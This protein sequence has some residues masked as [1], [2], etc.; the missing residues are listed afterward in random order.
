M[1]PAGRTA[2]TAAFKPLLLCQPAVGASSFP[3]VYGQKPPTLHEMQTGSCDTRVA[4]AKRFGRPASFKGG[5]PL[6]A[7]LADHR[8]LHGT[9]SGG[10]ASLSVDPAVHELHNSM[11]A[12]GQFT[13][14]SDH[15]HSVVRLPQD[16]VQV[17]ED[18]VRLLAVQIPRGLIGEQN[19]G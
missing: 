8:I 14:M 10:N 12:P 18:T 6:L 7:D 13:V 5:F 11:G 19:G 1:I 17:R 16:S 9:P 3:A 15:D 2:I 4:D